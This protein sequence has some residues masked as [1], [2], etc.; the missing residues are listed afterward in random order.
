M[1]CTKGHPECKFEMPIRQDQMIQAF[2]LADLYSV[3]TPI[4]KRFLR[5]GVPDDARYP[6]GPR[7]AF[8]AYPYVWR[9]VPD[10]NVVKLEMGRDFHGKRIVALFSLKSENRFG[11]LVHV[12]VFLIDDRAAEAAGLP[13]EY[14]AIFSEDLR[15]HAEAIKM[16]RGS[17]LRLDLGNNRYVVLPPEELPPP[18]ADEE[19]PLPPSDRHLGE[20]DNL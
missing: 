11:I 15:Y 7:H 2:R 6:D 18:P 19:P 16:F 5:I 13:P 8:P 14:S 20:I 10:H 4:E 9:S 1:E 17:L 3:D 12:S